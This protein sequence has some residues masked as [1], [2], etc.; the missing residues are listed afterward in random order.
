MKTKH[1]TP[2]ELNVLVKG[3]KQ[4][5][6]STV[7]ELP[8]N[9]IK[10]S[11]ITNIRL[12]RQIIKKKQEKKQQRPELPRA[13]VLL[14]HIKTEKSG[15]L[16]II[17][18]PALVLVLA[19]QRLF[20]VVRNRLDS[21]CAHCLRKPP[22]PKSLCCQDNQFAVF[23]NG[24]FRK[25]L[26]NFLIVNELVKSELSQLLFDFDPDFVDI[27][28]LLF[29]GSCQSEFL[30]EKIREI[31]SSC[32]QHLSMPSFNLEEMKMIEYH[33]TQ[34]MRRQTAPIKFIPEIFINQM[35][36]SKT[37]HD[38]LLR[39][40]LRDN[41]FREILYWYV[42]HLMR[43]LNAISHTKPIQSVYFFE[44]ILLDKFRN[45]E[46]WLIDCRYQYEFEGGHIRGAFNIND[47]KVIK[48][49][50]F[51]NNWAKDAEFVEHLERFRDQH[52]D[53]NK[54]AG[55]LFEYGRALAIRKRNELRERFRLKF[56]RDLR[57]GTRL[58]REFEIQIGI[59]SNE[60]DAKPKLIDKAKNPQNAVLSSKAGYRKKMKVDEIKRVRHKRKLPLILPK[61]GKLY[62]KTVEIGNSMVDFSKKNFDKVK[63]SSHINIMKQ[64]LKTKST[65]IVKDLDQNDCEDLYISRL[66]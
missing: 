48:M 52:I 42:G 63:N 53:R 34:A 8:Q 60:R 51:E 15:I 23:F 6:K 3:L 14:P 62:D 5:H 17:D 7:K 49:L 61:L 36:I 25:Y 41:L 32:F 57:Y 59:L 35:I 64:L 58:Q 20:G 44:S 16:Q 19:S 13:D 38:P 29:N 27:F 43:K 56:K 2:K 10:T 28:E 66:I 37:K 4:F 54:A 21:I 39:L 22:N 12:K 55:I 50:F 9:N 26:Q 65:K 31:N 40:A 24:F 18:S 1:S 47:P 45:S 33:R 11:K 46:I 30:L